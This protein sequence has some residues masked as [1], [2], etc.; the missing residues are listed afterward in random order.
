MYSELALRSVSWISAV[1]LRFLDDPFEEVHLIEL[2][3][4]SISHKLMET[5]A[6]CVEPCFHIRPCWFEQTQQE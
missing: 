6:A 3:E 2:T 1:K 5:L 4:A